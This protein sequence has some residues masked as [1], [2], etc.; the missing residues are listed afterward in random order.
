ML[1]TINETLFGKQPQFFDD[2]F[3]FK[4]EDKIPKIK[5]EINTATPEEVS[6]NFKKT[7]KKY[8]S[9][10]NTIQKDE[11]ITVHFN[12]EKSK[13]LEETIEKDEPCPKIKL[14][15]IENIYLKQKTDISLSNFQNIKKV[16]GIV[17]VTSNVNYFTVTFNQP[18]VNMRSPIP[19]TIKP[20][21]VGLITWIGSKTLKFTPELPFEKSMKYEVTL[22][23]DLS[24]TYQ[25]SLEK[26]VTVSITTP[27]PKIIKKFPVNLYTTQFPVIYLEFDQDIDINEIFNKISIKDGGIYETLKF[28]KIGGSKYPLKLLDVEKVKEIILDKKYSNLYHPYLNLIKHHYK[29]KRSIWFTLKNPLQQG[30]Q[31]QVKIAPGIKSL[32]GNFGTEVEEGFPF[33]VYSPLKVE[34]SQVTSNS[35]LI[36]KFTNPLNLKIVESKLFSISPSLS[37]YQINFSSDAKE[38]ILNGIFLGS[39]KFSLIFSPEIVDIFGQYILDHDIMFRIKVST[40]YFYMPSYV[41]SH[42]SQ[43]G[44]PQIFMLSRSISS[45]RVIVNQVH[46]EEDFENSP[47]GSNFENQNESNIIDYCSVGKN[48]A[49]FIISP[50][51]KDILEETII[52]LN[53]YLQYPKLNLGHLLIC[54]EPMIGNERVRKTVWIQS[55]KQSIDYFCAN[56]I[57]YAWSNSMKNG[58][59][60]EEA[61]F[62]RLV[63]GKQKLKETVISGGM[64]KID[65]VQEKFDRFLLF[66]KIDNDISFLKIQ[67]SKEE[68]SHFKIFIFNWKTAYNSSDDVKLRAIIRKRVKTNNFFDL[69]NISDEEIKFKIV[70]EQG[71]IITE[72]NCEILKNSSFNIDFSLKDVNPG[73]CTLKVII[74][75][76]IFTNFFEVL[77]KVTPEFNFV[78]KMNHGPY[79]LNDS[80][81]FTTEV[82]NKLLNLKGDLISW[83]LYSES[84]SFIPTGWEKSSYVFSLPRDFENST[85][86]ISSY[87]A[88]LN[89]NGKHSIRIDLNEKP[90][91]QSFPTKFVIQCEYKAIDLQI[92]STTNSFLLHP[93]EYYVGMKCDTSFSFRDKSVPISIIVTDINGKLIENISIL[94]EI[95]NHK[96]E[97]VDFFTLKSKDKPVIHDFKTKLGGSI[98]IVSS[99]L[100]SKNRKNSSSINIWTIEEGKNISRK[101]SNFYKFQM[102]LIPDKKTYKIGETAEIL[103]LSPFTEKSDGVVLIV[104]ESIEIQSKFTIQSGESHGIAKI[105]ISQHFIPNAYVMVYLTVPGG[106]NQPA[107]GYGICNISV[108][109]LKNIL[110]VDLELDQNSLT[111][112]EKTKISVYGFNRYEEL[113]EN[114]EAMLNV[115]ETHHGNEYFNQN[116]IQTFYPKRVEKKIDSSS[117][118]YY[119]NKKNLISTLFSQTQ[120]KRTVAQRPHALQT[121]TVFSLT[122]VISEEFDDSGKII[123]EP[124]LLNSVG[125]FKMNCLVQQEKNF[126]IKQTDFFVNHKVEISDTFPRWLHYGDKSIEFCLNIKNNT[127]E[128]KTFKLFSNFKNLSL[129]SDE[130]ISIDIQSYESGAVSFILDSVSPGKAFIEVFISND[131]LKY[132]K[133]L[134]KDLNVIANYRNLTHFEEINE[135]IWSKNIELSEEIKSS[136]FK[137]NL[138]FSSSPFI[139]LLNPIFALISKK[140]ETLDQLASE[141]L[142]Y[143]TLSSELE[144]SNIPSL[145]SVET[146]NKLIKNGIEKLTLCQQVS[147]GWG[148]WSKKSPINIFTSIHISQ[149]LYYCKK[150]GYEIPEESIEKA[151]IFLKSIDKHISES[152][153]NLNDPITIHSLKAF[154]L[155]V[156]NN[157]GEDKEE[158]VKQCRLLLKKCK[159]DKISLEGLAWLMET[160]FLSSYLSDLVEFLQN[161]L[162]VLNTVEEKSTGIAHFG[163]SYNNDGKSIMFHS[164]IRTDAIILSAL[165]VVDKTHELVNKLAKGLIN[166]VKSEPLSSLDSCFIL[167]SLKMYFYAFEKENNANDVK[168]WFNENFIKCHTS[169]KAYSMMELPLNYSKNQSKLTFDIEDNIYCRIGI[170]FPVKNEEINILHDEKF[171]FFIERIYENISNDKNSIV[172]NEKGIWKIKRGSIVRVKIIINVLERRDHISMIDF[173]PSGFINPIEENMGIQMTNLSNETISKSTWF[174]TQ[175]FKNDQIKVFSAFLSPGIFEYSYLCQAMVNGDFIVPA[176]EI[177]EIYSP[178]NVGNSNFSQVQIFE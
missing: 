101:P 173:L 8:S 5:I 136:D 115:V 68:K 76:S 44:S 156:L 69:K 20:Q 71:K 40:P 164:S 124:K 91:I 32:N 27:T 104:S 86:F 1:S 177:K 66:S 94:I 131:E 47:I 166:A 119:L 127:S 129:K 160:M 25:N 135:K 98:S 162:I 118:F 83:L 33:D 28:F 100:D 12:T 49:D 52:D 178:E 54:V 23:K 16:L 87:D 80:I 139:Y 122:D 147:G 63:K 150:E 116:L 67:K 128:N 2:E 17:S 105:P 165:L 107:C 77:P 53:S 9:N 117:R 50:K 138:I 36:V 114:G 175:F 84:V 144:I 60:F 109:P 39:N 163:S 79:T 146:I 172:Q 133:L 37:D 140:S 169:K 88:K 171:A 96:S 18:M 56:G 90:K 113:I 167:K 137:C 85:N 161:V 59:T 157:F 14:D 4:S 120:R 111:P 153:Y 121:S 74:E 43:R 7:N 51:G 29:E 72:G 134:H 82:K 159:F 58:S 6:E 148:S 126:G 102:E 112:G 145:P 158:I 61:E 174:E 89:S 26:P 95:C 123:L 130:N 155:F 93:S 35:S 143:L 106:G 57:V 3:P 48:V 97:I 110:K 19:L 11:K 65:T 41:L 15:T 152:K 151:K 30:Y 81:I 176:V 103:M 34:S 24:S 38:L 142:I 13:S 45:I 75:D 99:V 141:I 22:H 92:H 108:P 42:D 149:A 78:T 73:K 62:Y 154:S 21:V 125:H 170:K 55:T 10:T 168:I 64:T 70:N 46:P 132:E 31:Y